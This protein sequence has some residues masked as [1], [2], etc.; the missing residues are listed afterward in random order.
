M[1]KPGVVRRVLRAFWN[2]ITRLR[3]ALSNLLFLLVLALLYFVY[4]GRSPL[5]FP[6][7]AALLVNPVGTVVDQKSY[8]DPL[9]ALLGRPSPLNNEVLLRDII[10]AI[11][12]AAG[13][14][15]INALVLELDDLLSLG[16]SKTQEV[17]VAV[18]AFRASG[19]PVIA[20]GDYYTQGQYLLASHADTV[21]VHPLGGV[22]LEGFAS[23]RQHF[24]EALE[25]LSVSMHVFHAGEFKSAAEPLVRDDMSEG[26]KAITSRWLNEVWRQYT[27]TVEAQRELAAG[28]VDDFVNRYDEHLAAHAG[29]L[30]EASL[31]Q[32]LVDEIM[33]R[34][35]ANDYLVELV[36]ASDSEGRYEAVTFAQY[37]ARK[38][39]H[40]KPGDGTVAVVTAE[41]NILDGDHPPGS[42]GGDSL[43]RQLRS[44][45]ER[46]DVKAVVLRVN[47]G[48][49]SAFASEIIRQAI[50]DLQAEGMPLVVSMGAVAGSG[51]YYIAAGA[52][53]VIATP[54][55]ITGS[56]GVFAA[57]P[58][59][60]RLLDRFG[61][62]SDGVATT[63]LAG[64]ARLDRPLSP[65]VERAVQLT[66]QRIYDDFIALVADGREMDP[67]AVDAVAQGRVWSA[68]DAV[69]QG[70]VD[71]LGTL[72]DAVVSAA[73]LA[74]LTQYRVEFVEPALS[75]REMLMRQFTDRAHAWGL[76]GR[77]HAAAAPL[78]RL[79][80]PL[81]SSL[82]ALDLRGDPAQTYLLCL[83]CVAP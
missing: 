65:V 69:E 32:G 12:L 28:T 78:A 24:R 68:A 6:E 51:G 46:E 31:A 76:F 15:G 72:D 18:E 3:L 75:P 25:K 2:G 42:I 56:I 11:E 60:E 55:T 50:L 57:F 36:G 10:D 33:T 67:A 49:G 8:V 19:K 53:E 35:A 58:T 48:G 82:D 1:S 9:Q 27:G 59:F 81:L 44:L 52:D 47:S 23:Y 38:R 80:E 73:G 83:P 4:V 13:D 5:P 77:G 71:R 63:E 54:A 34:A 79:V 17:A 30:A 22:A 20:L 43:A 40:Q 64:G 41:G 26:E 61:V 39:P 66:V 37:A 70:L 62:H 74:G 45:R 16:T 14:P 7:R 21:I 29:N